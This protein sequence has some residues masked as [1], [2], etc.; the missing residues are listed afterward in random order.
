MM[1]GVQW[2]MAQTEVSKTFCKKSPETT[3][4]DKTIRNRNAN[5]PEGKPGRIPFIYQKSNYRSITRKL[6]LH[7]AKIF[8][9]LIFNLTR[10]SGW[11]RTNQVII[12]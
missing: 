3:P 12:H 5:I 2:F 9:N 1:D 8:V 4:S 11:V 6:L 7:K 10:Y